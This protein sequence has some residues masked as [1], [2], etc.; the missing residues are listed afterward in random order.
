MNKLLF[1]RKWYL[2]TTKTFQQQYTWKEFSLNV[3][4]L[5]GL[6]KMYELLKTK[7]YIV[8]FDLNGKSRSGYA[9]YGLVIICF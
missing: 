9:E 7:D 1:S 2:I 8:R 6:R 4:K 3:L 5:K